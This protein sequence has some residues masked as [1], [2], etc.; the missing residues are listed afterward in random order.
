MPP[1]CR[2]FSL[3]DSSVPRAWGAHRYCRRV[4]C[5]EIVRSIA[6]PLETPHHFFRPHMAVQGP[7]RHRCHG[8]PEAVHEQRDALNSPKAVEGPAFCNGVAG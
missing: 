4:A 3:K 8:P 1:R 2:S 6:H 5:L 7:R